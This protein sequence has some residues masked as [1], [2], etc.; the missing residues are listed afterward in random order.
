MLLALV[1]FFDNRKLKDSSDP[2]GV[3]P[4][5][6][7]NYVW[8]ALIGYGIGLVAAL[9][10]GILSQSPQPAVLYLVSVDLTGYTAGFRTPLSFL[11][12]ASLTWFAR[13]RF[14]AGIFFFLTVFVAFRCH[15]LWG[16]LCTCH[17]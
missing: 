15:R 10:A 13:A 4:S 2:T 3:S 9:A 5:K 17:G 12:R 8:Y 1:L 6:R 7:R 14:V 16:L 11:V